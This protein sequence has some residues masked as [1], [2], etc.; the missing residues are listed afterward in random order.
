MTTTTTSYSLLSIEEAALAAAERGFGL[1][2]A[3]TPEAGTRGRVYI[4]RDLGIGSF[5]VNAFYQA[6]SGTFVVGEHDETGPGTSGHE[7]LYVVVEGSCTFTVNGDEIDAPRGTALF[8]G[9]PAI[10]RLA[11][12]TSDGTIVLVVGGR[13]GEAFRPGPGEALGP[14]FRLYRSGD[15]E[16]ALAA[17]RAALE[18]HPTDALILYN[19]ACL[20]SVLGRPEPALE[21]LEAALEAWPGYRE[22]AAGDTDLSPLHDDARFQ[23]LVA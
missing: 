3:P 5:G 19:T 20:E 6:S 12:A 15:Y 1:E 22:E 2:A 23:A 16:G 13:P 11:R 14:F 4:R 18:S 9:D 21:A 8:V 17:C 10:R 7:E